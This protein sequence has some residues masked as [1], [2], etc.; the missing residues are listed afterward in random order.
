MQQAI[1]MSHVLGWDQKNH[2]LSKGSIEPESIIKRPHRNWHA[3]PDIAHTAEVWCVGSCYRM[4]K[5]RHN[6]AVNGWWSIKP[7]VGTVGSNIQ[8]SL[9]FILFHQVQIRMRWEVMHPSGTQAFWRW[10]VHLVSASCHT[11]SVIFFGPT[12]HVR[13]ISPCLPNFFIFF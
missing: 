8:V 6:V 4:E 3:S 12:I 7:Q 13:T 10:A 1:A 9:S 5:S 2:F 11:C